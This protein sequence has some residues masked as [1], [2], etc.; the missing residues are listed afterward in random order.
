MT[1]MCREIIIELLLALTR[2]SEVRIDADSISCLTHDD[3]RG[4]QLRP[5]FDLDS[6]SAIGL[7][8]CYREAPAIRVTVVFALE[9]SCS[10]GGQV[11]R[12]DERELTDGELEDRKSEARARLQTETR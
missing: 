10:E 12:V 8:P 9:E 11:L 2:I 5:L 4:A 7:S 3:V 1:A 6:I